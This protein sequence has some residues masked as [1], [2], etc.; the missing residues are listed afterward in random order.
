M[1]IVTAT[2]WPGGDASGSYELMHATLTN[3]SSPRDRTE[4]YMAHLLLRPNASR[5][6]PGYE[7]DVEVKEHRYENGF[8]P[9][10]TSVL[11]AADGG[12]RSSVTGTNM[13]TARTLARVDLVTAQQFEGM[14]RGRPGS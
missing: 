1:I 5:G 10:L 6:L 13:P 2:M 4:S 3:R 14:L 9:L 7:A 8:V 12:T 11:M